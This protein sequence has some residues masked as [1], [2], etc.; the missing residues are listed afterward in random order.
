MVNGGITT[1][2]MN[3]AFG[4]ASYAH[5]DHNGEVH[6]PVRINAPITIRL[7]L[8]TQDGR[9]ALREQRNEHFLELLSAAQTL[10]D[11]VLEAHALRLEV[12]D[13]LASD[14]TIRITSAQLREAL[15]NP[16]CAAALDG[17]SRT[18]DKSTAVPRDLLA[19]ARA[20]ANRKDLLPLFR[21]FLEPLN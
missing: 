15:G 2:E 12:S 21:Q 7:F 8:N 1:P 13:A 3:F 9:L 14:V 20:A 5:S 4:N 19:A 16:A 17:L 10:I 6:A 11:Q 18:M